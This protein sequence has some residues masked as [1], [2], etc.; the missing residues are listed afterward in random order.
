MG[1]CSS[2][3]RQADAAIAQVQKRRQRQQ[4]TRPT[5]V[6]A[7]TSTQRRKVSKFR[8][9]ITA[10]PCL[11]F[12]TL[13][14]YSL[15]T[16]PPPRTEDPP[17]NEPSA[18]TPPPP[19]PRADLLRDRTLIE[20]SSANHELLPPLTRLPRHPNLLSPRFEDPPDAPAKKIVKDTP[21]AGLC[22]SKIS[23]LK[24]R[25]VT[26]RLTY[27]GTT[28]ALSIVLLLAP[29]KSKCPTLLPNPLLLL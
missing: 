16:S 13:L 12:L 22:P 27:P 23:M 7:I 6:D 28:A 9:L 4:K 8:D 11:L 26:L 29:P 24:K 25:P 19:P 3:T 1:Q 20:R 15:P 18:Q 2:S 10:Q 17:T 14:F 5:P 21:E